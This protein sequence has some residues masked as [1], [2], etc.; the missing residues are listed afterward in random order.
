[1]LRSNESF[2]EENGHFDEPIRCQQAT[3]KRAAMRLA[4]ESRCRSRVAKRADATR[5]AQRRL[6][7]PQGLRATPPA[8]RH[9]AGWKKGDGGRKGTFYL[10]ESPKLGAGLLWGC[11]ITLPVAVAGAITTP[12]QELF[13]TGIV[14]L[15]VAIAVL[16]GVMLISRV[17]GGAR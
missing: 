2:A 4:K 6:R 12:S 1:V 3:K 9:D 11:A 13:L 5:R 8:K 7:C 17:L 15:V 10:F 14:I 16:F